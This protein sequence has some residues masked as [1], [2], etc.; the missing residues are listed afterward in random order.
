MVT[1]VKDRQCSPGEH[2]R[3]IL[4]RATWLQNFAKKTV[5]IGR[6]FSYFPGQMH[7]F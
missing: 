6:A 2:T 5:V 1:L 4:P 3:Q 7:L